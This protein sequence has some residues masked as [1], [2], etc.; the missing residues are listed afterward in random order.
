MR[1]KHLIQPSLFAAAYV[2]HQIGREL[3][4]MSDW[5]DQHPELLDLVAQDIDPE[6]RSES[7]RDGLTFESIL[8]CAILKQYRQVSYRELEFLLEDSRSFAHF[9]RLDPLQVPG[10][11]TLQWVVSR[12]T[13]ATW[14]TL[15]AALLRSACA[16]GIESG[17]TVRIDATVTETNILEPT[18]SRLLFDGV[19]VM[20]R[21]LQKAHKHLGPARI[22]FHN[23]RR[24]AKRRMRAIHSARG[25]DRRAVLYR[26]LIA[27]VEATLGYVAA[28]LPAVAACSAPWALVWRHEVDHYRPLIEQV[29]DQTRRRVFDGET[30]PAGEKIVSLF[31]PH[32]DIIR[33]EP[34]ETEYG[35]KVTLSTGCSALVLDAVV[36][37]GNP[38]D[39][40]CYL[41]MLERHAEHYGQMPTSVATD[42]AYASQD[43]LDAAKAAGI[44]NVVF[45]KRR[46]IEIEA[47]TAKRWLYYQLKRFRAGIEAGISYL[48]RCFGLGR[49]NWKGLAHFKAYVW[50]AIF[51]HNL[52]VFGR[53]RTPA[54]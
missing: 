37:A 35:H 33:K 12:I 5:L 53:L 11:S 38:A 24:V 15:N 20:N 14:E 8:R 1:K 36:E 54:T 25:A 10:H 40:T 26:E 19:R 16:E 28:A 2:D 49:C 13:D 52:V 21:L 3:A 30:V 50:S 29:I 17:E 43:N 47:M 23:H 31:E 39:A 48:K 22:V 27:K 51:A 4:A 46:G 9:A 32:T 42:G 44:E 41:P 18:D 45:H 7:G 6:G 34:R